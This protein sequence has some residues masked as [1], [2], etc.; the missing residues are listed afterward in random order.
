MAGKGI[1]S[2]L[3]A[4][5]HQL[6]LGDDTFVEQHC[7]NKTHEELRECSKAHWRSLTLPLADYKQRYSNRNEAMAQAYKSG[8]YTMA[9]IAE[10]FDVHYMT[11]SR[12]VREAEEK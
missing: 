10:S 12:A 8:A 9:H 6:I 5:Q 4:I 1:P 11:V 2:P 7:R 3:L